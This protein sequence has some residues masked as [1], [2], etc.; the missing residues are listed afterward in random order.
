MF[1]EACGPDRLPS[2]GKWDGPDPTLSQAP[3]DRAVSLWLWVGLGL[4]VRCP[5][6]QDILTG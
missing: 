4:S 3:T 6:T 2:D 5:H 1:E